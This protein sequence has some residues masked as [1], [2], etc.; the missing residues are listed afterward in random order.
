MHKKCVAEHTHPVTGVCIYPKVN[1]A[2]IP[3][4]INSN[5]HITV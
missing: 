2:H 4:V 1:R 3:E 5:K